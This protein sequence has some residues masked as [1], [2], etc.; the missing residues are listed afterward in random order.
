M[1][2]D[3][4]GGGGALKSVGRISLTSLGAAVGRLGRLEEIVTDEELADFGADLR[5]ERSEQIPDQFR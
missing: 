5:R 1:P 3:I 2:S 4:W